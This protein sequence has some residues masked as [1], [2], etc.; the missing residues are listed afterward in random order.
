MS[1]RKTSWT[2]PDTQSLNRIDVLDSQHE[3]PSHNLRH[4]RL[5]GHVLCP[6]VER[7][8]L[9]L[10]AQGIP[11]QDVQINLEKRTRWHY[12]IN[13]GFVPI[14]ETPA[15]GGKYGQRSA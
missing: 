14:L 8:R 10:A 1:V 9:V 4:L 13:G 7:V 15:Q 5:Y 12:S 2:T 3:Q 11:Y 6:F